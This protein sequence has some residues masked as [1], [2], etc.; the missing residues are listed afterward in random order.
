MMKIRKFLE[1]HQ[2]DCE[3]NDAE[4]LTVPD[5]CLTVREILTRFT[6]GTLDVKPSVE[7]GADDDID[8]LD[9]NFDD[10]VDA[11]EAFDNGSLALDQLRESAKMV[12]K[13]EN[14]PTPE[15]A[16]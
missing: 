2:C 9:S 3:V 7:Q 6:C 12:E 4:S 11:Q 14:P 1:P 16:E 13:P 5:D 8:Q 10:I 15:P